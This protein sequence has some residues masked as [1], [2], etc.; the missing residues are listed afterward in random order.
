M[1]SLLRLQQKIIN[2]LL[3]DPPKQDDVI[4]QV[5]AMLHYHVF[6]F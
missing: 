6:L 1:N 4:K 5:V 3:K 2:L